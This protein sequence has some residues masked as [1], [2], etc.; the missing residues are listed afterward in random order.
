MAEL[1]EQF[2]PLGHID[3]Y[4]SNFSSLSND[5]RLST[6]HLHFKNATSVR[7]LQ[8]NLPQFLAYPYT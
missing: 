1:T 3:G 8:L 7:F 4:S 5:D 2:F 6:A